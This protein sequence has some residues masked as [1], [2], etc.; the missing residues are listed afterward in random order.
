MI[1][2]C[3]QI[4]DWS[5]AK[6]SK[7]LYVS[8]DAY[9][10][11]PSYLLSYRELNYEHGNKGLDVI[12]EET[13]LWLEEPYRLFRNYTVYYFIKLFNDKIGGI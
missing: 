13:D 3:P 4:L 6:L 2:Y 1:I 7:S 8:K 10:E 12:H 9:K 5:G 11:L